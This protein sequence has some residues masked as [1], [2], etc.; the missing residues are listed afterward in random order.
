MLYNYVS[1]ENHMMNYQSFKETLS[2][3]KYSRISVTS[4][5]VSDSLKKVILG[6]STVIDS[7][8]A[9]HFVYSHERISVHL[10]MFSTSM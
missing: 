10:A 7:L 9:E 5:D 2:I 3:T 8:A 4:S 1:E 6:K